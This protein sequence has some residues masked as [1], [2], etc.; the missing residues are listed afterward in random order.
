MIEKAQTIVANWHID[1]AGCGDNALITG[2]PNRMEQR[3]IFYDSAG[4]GYIAEGYSLT[5]QKF[6]IRQNTLLEFFAENHLPGIYPF[7]RT[8][9]GEHGVMAENL[10]WQIRPFIIAENI[11][12]SSLCE[13]EEYGILWGEFLLQMKALI[14]RTSDLPSMYNPN[15]YMANQLPKLLQ[16]AERKMPS[17]TG[18]IREFEQKLSPFF[19]WERKAVGMFAHGDYHPANVLMGKK[20]INVV[21][22]WEFGGF[23]FPGYDMALM[24]GCLAM[25]HPDNLASPAVRAFL[26]ILHQNKFIPN[27]AWDLLPQMVAAT[28][29][30]WLGEWL[31]L[32]DESLVRQE[33]AL[34]SILLAG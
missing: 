12:R 9:S 6:Q 22:D 31:L 28:R 8:R 7:I 25:D 15:F 30:G 10:F 16:F 5:K 3:F 29:M 19:K 26:N 24:I 23:K 17:I 14:D 34:L 4:Q 21:I 32:D 33:I 27:E 1:F 18:S 11:P 13:H 20:R 2:S